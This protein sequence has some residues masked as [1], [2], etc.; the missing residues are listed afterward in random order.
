MTNE[1]S[2]AVEILGCNIK[3]LRKQ[4]NI[5]QEQLAESVG[6]TVKYISLLERSL[7]FPS[8]DTLDAIAR[9][10]SVPV[11][12]LFIP[13]VIQSKQLIK[14]PTSFLKNELIDIISKLD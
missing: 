7:S 13:D 1:T 12:K 6:V 11:F 14:L 2:L 3:K 8:A 5:T 9:A 10:L 4:R